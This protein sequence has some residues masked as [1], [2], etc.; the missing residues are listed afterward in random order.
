M[1]ADLNKLSLEKLGELFPVTIV[2]YNPKWPRIFFEEK[3]I[4][5]AVVGI[6]NIIRIEHIGST[7][8]PGLAAKPTIDILIEIED[9]TGKDIIIEYLKSI[10]YHFIP[11]PENPPPHMMFAKGYSEK[12]Y[13]GQ[14]YH[15]HI[16]YKGDW[17]EITFR[18]YLLNHPETALKYAE[19]KY[20][21][22]ADYIN[23]REAYTESKTEFIKRVL[24]TA[25]KAKG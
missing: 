5:Q 17:H 20:K 25:R 13:A 9:N 11:K 10:G 2:E 14:T 12:G 6:N 15:I 16:R 7:A 22:A 8:I 3:E 19:L 21:L 18:D 1:A 23:D 4:I 24:H